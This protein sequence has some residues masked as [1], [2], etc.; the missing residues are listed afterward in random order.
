MVRAR[1]K[2][3]RRLSA[4]KALSYRHHAFAIFFS[5]VLAFLKSKR[6]YVIDKLLRVSVAVSLFAGLVFALALSGPVLAKSADKASPQTFT[7]VDTVLHANAPKAE[8]CLSLSRPVDA[9]DRNR[10]MSFIELKKDGKKVKISASDLSLTPH[11][12]CVQNLEHRHAYEVTLQRIQSADGMRLDKKYVTRVAVPD[13]KPVLTFVGDKRRLILPRHVREAEDKTSDSELV[14]AGMA[15]VV[16]SVNVMATHLTLYKIGDRKLLSEAWQQFKQMNL[17]PSESLYFARQ[18]GQVVFE[19][20]LVFGE[21]PNEDQTLVAPLPAEKELTPGLYYLAAT[22]RGKEDKNPGLFAGQWF[23]VSD[24]RIGVV[25]LR[26]GIKF[27]ATAGGDVLSSVPDV[28]V[29]ALDAKGD[30]VAEAK[31]G[32][33]GSVFL[34]LAAKELAQVAIVTGQK[35]T[36]DLDLFEMGPDRTITANDIA[37][38]PQLTLDKTVYRAGQTAVVT[39]RAENAKGEAQDV[40]E[41]VVQV[42]GPDNRVFSEKPVA[43]GKK[44]LS[45]LSVPVPYGQTP[46]TWSVAWRKKEGSLLAAAPLVITPDGVLPSLSLIVDRTTIDFDQTTMALLKAQD[47]AKKPRAFQNGTLF[48]KTA[49]PEIAGWRHYHFGDMTAKGGAVVYQTRFMTDADGVARVPVALD[50]AAKLASGIEGLRFEA[51]LEDGGTA[52]PITVPTRPRGDV[53]VGLKSRLEGRAIPENSMA[54]FD[55]IAIDMA[56]KR[57]ALGDL[58]YLV[59]E[60]GRSFEWVQSEGHWDYRQRPDHRR[61]GG[62]PLAISASGET[63]IRWPVTAG[64]YLLEVTN[65]AGDVLARYSFDAGRREDAVLRQDEASLRFVDADKPFEMKANNRLKIFVSE[66]AMVSVLVTDGAVR[67]AQ[68]RFMKAGINEVEITPAEGWGRQVLVRVV[69]QMTHS[70]EPVLTQKSFS[71]HVPANDLAIKLSSSGAITTGRTVSLPLQIQKQQRGLPTFVSVIATPQATNGKALPVLVHD[72]VSVTADGRAEVV[73]ALPSFDGTLALSVTAWN[74]T[75]KGTLQTTLPA[76][77]VF[78]VDGNLP[79]QVTVG[80]KINTRLFLTNGTAAPVAV[81]YKW[82]VPDGLVLSGAESGKVRLNKGERQA[83]TVAMTVRG[84]VSDE[85][86]LTVQGIG[87][88]GGNQVWTWPVYAAPEPNRNAEERT[89]TLDPA[90]THQ[91]PFG[92]GKDRVLLV[93]PVAME[94]ALSDLER[95]LHS[96]PQTTTEIAQWLDVTAVWAPVIQQTGLM[97]E[98]SLTRLRDA[99]VQTLLVRQNEDGGFPVLE[100]GSPSDLGSTAAALKVLAGQS[101]PDVLFAAQWLSLRLQNTWFEES[102]RAPR[103]LAFEALATLGKVDLSGLRYFAEKSNDKASDP[104]VAAALARALTIAG[105]ETP[106]QH[107]AKKILA[108]RDVPWDA[109]ALMA[110]NDKIS[111]EDVFKLVPASKSDAPLSYAE[112]M[113]KLKTLGAL[114]Q[115]AGTWRTEKAGVESKHYGIWGIRVSAQEKDNAAAFKNV[116]ERK[117]FSTT[118]FSDEPQKASKSRASAMEG[119]LY[120]LEGRKVEDG[121]NLSRDRAYLLSIEASGNKGTP[122][123]SLIASLPALSAYDFSAPVKADPILLKRLYPWSTGIMSELD[124]VTRG[125]AG[126]GFKVQE[127]KGW[128]TLILVRPKHTGFYALPLPELR[129]EGAAFEARRTVGRYWVE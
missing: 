60:E 32:A 14:R 48:V 63:T 108:Q 38:Q 61:V 12:I 118:S 35:A 11:D 78:G 40:G 92:Q 109:L 13:R 20:D 71:I 86:M 15:H 82:K 104:V 49:Q 85:V 53:M 83:L 129:R 115:K 5:K 89:Q 9:H 19:S 17:S 116:G 121:T 45:V 111:F 46:R 52:Q 2:I 51:V 70:F 30:V 23:L 100:A 117:L 67:Q 72:K 88:T 69:A 114:S 102:E 73:L 43:A 39:L 101:G 122:E 22:P 4:P 1:K 110:T 18:K 74:D 126:L 80:D 98:K 106:T 99:Q 47:S 50:Q 56:G 41:S 21:A 59:Y 123:A 55:A 16:R 112:V 26:D 91:T 75:Q 84:P 6:L 10:I 34:P 62:G 96:T 42:I 77:P 29:A 76:R 27:L 58:Y 124:G 64:T 28:T 125:E 103:A 94:G 31:T 128:G 87:G 57:R 119:S 90:Q 44:G 37:L 24:L 120:T 8:I 36:G 93:A 81:T 113:W 107:W 97:N 79:A 33:D 7:L 66:S 65:A 3:L 105:D 127:G 95:I 68:H 54:Q 25:R